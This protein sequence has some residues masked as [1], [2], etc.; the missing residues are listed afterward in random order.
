VVTVPATLTPQEEERQARERVR[1]AKRA[2]RAKQSQYAAA[3][4][5]DVKRHPDY[6]RCKCGLRG[7]MTKDDLLPLGAGCTAPNFICPVLDR[8]RRLVG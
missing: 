2:G 3:I 4:W 6:S 7:G 1:R 5:R 8:Y